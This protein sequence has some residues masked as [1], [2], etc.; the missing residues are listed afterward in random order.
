[1]HADWK[2]LSL[3]E[4]FLFFALLT[5]PFGTSVQNFSFALISLSCLIIGWRQKTPWPKLSWVE[6]M[7]LVFAL[8][9]TCWHMLASLLNPANPFNSYA[10]YFLG[11]APV[12]VLPFLLSWQQVDGRRIFSKFDSWLPYIL[13]AWFLIAVSQSLIGWS[14]MR[15]LGEWQN[16]RPHG[17]YSHPLSLA[18]AALLFW[19]YG[20]NRVLSNWRISA[21]WLALISAGGILVLTNSRTAVAAAV[22]ILAWLIVR[23]LRGKTLLLASLISLSAIVVIGTTTNPVSTKITATLTATDPDRFSDYPDDRLAFWHAHWKMIQ[24]R[25]LLGH[26]AHLNTAYRLPYYD[27]IG[28]S[29]FEKKYAAHN[30]Y[31]QVLANGG[32]PSLIMLLGFFGSIFYLMHRK[33]KNSELVMWLSPA[34]TLFMLGIFTQNA[35]DDSVVRYSLSLLITWLYCLLPRN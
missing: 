13:T 24:E 16:H 30:Q 8:G 17:L 20:I 29:E 25:P 32:L 22:L 7:P 12:F 14:M 4:K 21:N 19:P 26:G 1:M 33:M 15:G 10:S 3:L 28:L 34:L 23:R 18:Y 5:F 35:Y 9:L 2:S 31:I 6:R 27:R 11:Y